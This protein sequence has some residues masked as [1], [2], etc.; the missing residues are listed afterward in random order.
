VSVWRARVNCGERDLSERKQNG[1]AEHAK[2]AKS[3]DALRGQD[4]SLSEQEVRA[5][6]S[7]SSACRWRQ[8]RLTQRLRGSHRVS[9]RKIRNGLRGFARFAIAF[10][11]YG[12]KAHNILLCVTLRLPLSLCVK[13]TCREQPKASLPQRQTP[14]HNS[15]SAIATTLVTLQAF[16]PPSSLISLCVFCVFCGFIQLTYCRQ[17]L[18]SRCRQLRRRGNGATYKR[19][20]QGRSTSPWRRLRLILRIPQ[21]YCRDLTRHMPRCSPP[22]QLD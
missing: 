22:E 11:T 12:P 4:D 13:R 19:T 15:W 6:P 8:V 21:G 14:H 18:A 5:L 10:P 1:T 16:Q 20:P 7:W 17:N 2:H 3:S 9:L